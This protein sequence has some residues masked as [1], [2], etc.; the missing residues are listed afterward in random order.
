MD[1][2]K[3]LDD[4]KD[5]KDMMERSSRFIS[6]SGLSGISAGILALVAAFLAYKFVYVEQ[7]LQSYK[8]VMLTKESLIAILLIAGICLV[9]SMVAGILFTRS[10]A[11]KANT[12]VTRK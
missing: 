10:K 6:L 1:K 8:S 3:Y 11:K 2:E 4:L 7:D 5:I 9:L 12:R